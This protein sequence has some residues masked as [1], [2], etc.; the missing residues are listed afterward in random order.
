MVRLQELV[1]CGLV[2]GFSG[3]Q[4][5]FA[6]EPLLAQVPARSPIVIHV[7]GTEAKRRLA[8]LIKAA[9]PDL[10][11]VVDSKLDEFIKH[12]LNGRE[13]SGLVMNGPIFL[14]LL[15]L[16]Q[17]DELIPKV[18]I[19]ARVTDYKAFRD[20][21]LKDQERQSLQRAPEGYEIATLEEAKTSVYFIKRQDHAIVTLNK[22]VAAQFTRE[23]AGLDR[24]IAKEL[25]NQLLKPDASLYV[26]MGAV[27]KTYGNH[28]ESARPLLYQLFES[29]Q[30]G[31]AG[32]LDK[33][34][35]EKTRTVVDALMQGITDSRALVLSLAFPPDGLEGHL[36]LHF[37]RD[38]KTNVYL[39][40]HSPF[41]ADALATLPVDQTG[42]FATSFSMVSDPFIMGSSMVEP[43]GETRHAVGEAVEQL[44]AA[45]PTRT[46]G[47]VGEA[48][49]FSVS[50]FRDIDKAVAAQLKMYKVLKKGS[51]W[52]QAV[53]KKA[54]LTVDKETYRG[55]TFHLVDLVW[56]FKKGSQLAP[57]ARAIGEGIVKTTI[58]E[59]LRMWVGTDGKVLVL[60][61]M[62]DW[63]AVRKYL[64]CYLDGKATLDQ[65]SN[66]HG[67]LKHIP[68]RTSLV[69]LVDVPRGAQYQAALMQSMFKMLPIPF[70]LGQPGKLGGAE[71]VYAGFS[72]TI[73]ATRLSLDLWLPAAGVRP[74]RKVFEP[75]FRGAA[76]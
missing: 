65:S 49:M 72:L 24:R 19:I 75:M 28:L 32:T 56:D 48:G 76:R 46:L 8:T 71:S 1:C 64:D 31:G 66:F 37:A 54:E 40:R 47:T 21:L 43:E 3:P 58:G 16:P 57:S 42:Y 6:Q 63:V 60:A 73:E 11:Q 23:Q 74:C 69:F 4:S 30:S 59:G 41:T 55:F 9:A 7:R 52:G 44:K 33:D 50:Q 25:A 5:T 68:A 20:G 13:L 70:K 35:K 45:G 12:G 10:S 2:F 34:Q 27:N 61:N 53:I 14:T 36:E 18:A 22:E 51:E 62:K 67:T 39:K 26:D 17:P 15:E 38:S 29:M